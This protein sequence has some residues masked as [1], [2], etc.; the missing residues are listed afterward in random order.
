MNIRLSQELIMQSDKTI[1]G[2]GAPINIIHGVGINPQ[3]VKNVIIHNIH[4]RHIFYGSGNNVIDV[5]V[6]FGLRTQNDEDGISN[7]FGNSNIWIDHVSMS[8]YVNGLVDAIEGSTGITISNSHFTDHNKAH[9]LTSKDKIM[10]VMIAFNHFGNRLIQR[11]TRCR[12]GFIHVINNDYT[13]W[14]MYAIEGNSNP[15][16]ISQGN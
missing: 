13:H 2:R 10:Q 3:F 11:M 5:V 6:H 16:I 14:N 15:T 1:D 8:N 4:I 7:I 9:D 12:W